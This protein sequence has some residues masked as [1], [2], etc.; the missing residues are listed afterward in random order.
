MNKLKGCHKINCNFSLGILILFNHKSC[1]SKIQRNISYPLRSMMNKLPVWWFGMFSF[2][3]T[4]STPPNT[5]WICL[6][7]SYNLSILLQPTP[8]HFYHTSSNLSIVLQ[9]IPHHSYHI[10][11]PCHIPLFHLTSPPFHSSCFYCHSLYDAMFAVFLI[12]SFCNLTKTLSS[13]LILLD[14]CSCALSSLKVS[15]RPSTSPPTVNLSLILSS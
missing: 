14:L 4:S 13:S 2:N 6:L 8:Y 7:S 5:Y 3:V 11:S 12:I 9:Y 10:S 15:L 1:L